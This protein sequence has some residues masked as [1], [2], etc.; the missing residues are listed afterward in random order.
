MLI[1]TQFGVSTLELS[2]S[3]LEVLLSYPNIAKLVATIYNHLQVA[4]AN[5]FQVS[6]RK[7]LILVP[8]FMVLF[9]GY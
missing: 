2:E 3:P 6:H 4:G 9:S 5:P 8:G 7:W 1:R